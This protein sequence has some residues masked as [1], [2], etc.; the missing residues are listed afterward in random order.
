[1]WYI[2]VG[3]SYKI[4][5]ANALSKKFKGELYIIGI[6]IVKNLD[7]PLHKENIKS[8]QKKAFL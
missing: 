4:F 3:L 1:M 5:L 7:Y 2:C 6:I 8:K